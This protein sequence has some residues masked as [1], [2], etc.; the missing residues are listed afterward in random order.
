MPNKHQ[1][2]VFREAKKNALHGMVDALNN[3]TI[4]ERMPRSIYTGNISEYF[5]DRF[6]PLRPQA[7]LTVLRESDVPHDS[8]NRFMTWTLYDFKD[9][10]EELLI[11]CLGLPK[12][13]IKPLPAKPTERAEE[14]SAGEGGVSTPTPDQ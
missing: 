2:K 10:M 5:D 4:P 13:R 14:G 9:Q 8:H 6:L 7:L 12:L 3:G 1:E 11:E